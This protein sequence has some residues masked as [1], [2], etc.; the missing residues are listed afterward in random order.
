MSGPAKHG[1]AGSLASPPRLSR[2]NQ[3]QLSKHVRGQH[4]GG[5]GQP[6]D[7]S[8]GNPT[9]LRISDTLGVCEHVGIDGD[10][11]GQFS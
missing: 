4:D 9:P 8:D 6:L 7:E 1:V 11:Q 5:L 10:P 2:E 3:H